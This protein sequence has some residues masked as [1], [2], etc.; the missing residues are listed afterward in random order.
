MKVAAPMVTA[1]PS[2][3]VSLLVTARDQSSVQVVLAAVAVAI[4]VVALIVLVE[5]AVRHVAIAPGA[6]K[7]D[8]RRLSFRID[9]VTIMPALVASFV[10]LLPAWLLFM[11]GSD[12]SGGTLARIIVALGRGQPLYLVLYAAL[13][14]VLTL[15]FTAMAVSP[16]SLAE[17]VKR[18]GG[19]LAGVAP[20]D[21]EGHLD[22]VLT[23]L[24]LFCVVYIVVLFMLPEVL[25]S[26]TDFP[27]YL[28]GSGLLIPVLV[29]LRLLLDFKAHRGAVAKDAGSA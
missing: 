11:V 12:P 4:L 20:A 25:I 28:G 19:G 6:G 1:L 15:Y 7:P 14:M 16:E 26:F 2:G 8:G 27:V 13:L 24:A 22:K 10:L 17:D 21:I 3:L 18:D 5:T 29:A 9:R 23:W